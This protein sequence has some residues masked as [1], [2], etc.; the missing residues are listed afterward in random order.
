MQNKLKIYVFFLGITLMSCQKEKVTTVTLKGIATSFEQEALILENYSAKMMQFKAEKHEIPL[1]KDKKFNYTFAIDKPG[2]YKIGRTFMYLSPG[3]DLEIDLT[4]GRDDTTFIGI[5]SEANNYLRSLPYPKGGSFWGNI[6]K[7]EKN[8][9]YKNMPSEFKKVMRKMKLELSELK[10]VSEEFVGLEKARLNFEYVN[11][12]QSVFY[13]YY[14][15]ARKREITRAQM[16]EKIVE[17][18]EF[19]IPF[20]AEILKDFKYRN[21]YL[22]FEVFQSIIYALNKE[23]FRIKHNL[24]ELPSELK[25]YILT[26]NLIDGFKKK[27]DVNSFAKSYYE[28]QKNIKKKEYITALE[29]IKNKYEKIIKGAEVTDL[30]FTNL[31]DDEVKLS[32]YK[33]KVIV[34]DLWATWCGPCMTEKPF[35]EKI[36]EKYKDKNVVFLTVSIDKRKIWKSYFKNE[37]PHGNQLH[38]YRKNLAAYQITGIPRFFVFDTK[39]K[40]V[41]VFAP[42]PSSGD[43]EKMIDNQ[44]DLH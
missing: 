44:L 16:Q 12:L 37:T 38:I 3:D 18:K 30:T 8:Y 19:Y 13:L 15:Q 2:Y 21:E 5:G 11:S 24:K 26:D 36:E 7:T 39:F 9:L 1:T 6:K 40:I 17:A 34:I 28:H 23:E 22:Q 31:N 10:N 35:F 41:D 43:L 25:E 32:D 20:V 33:G 42:S 29:S 4:Q 14:P 27:G